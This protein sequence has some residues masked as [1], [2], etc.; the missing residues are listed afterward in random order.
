MPIAGMPPY[1]SSHGE[2][3]FGGAVAATDAEGAPVH[4]SF[5]QQSSFS[6]MALATQGNVVPVSKDLDLATLA[7]LGCGIQT[8]AGGVLNS[9]QARAG[10]SIGVF[11][12]GAVGLSAVMAAQ[13][14]GCSRIVAVDVN[15]S[16]LD[17]ARQL[18][19]THTVHVTEAG[20]TRDLVLEATTGK[21]GLDHAFDTSG[22]AGVIRT[23]VECLANRGV[24]GFV[25]PGQQLA[26][27]SMSLLGG[28][29]LR[30]V[31]QGDSVPQTFIP[32]MVD[33]Y[34]GGRFP[35]DKLITFYDNGLE[36]LNCAIAETTAKDSAVIKPVLKISPQ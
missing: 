16:R 28:K 15:Q 13:V 3:N 14:A 6:T 17:I 34:L 2:L 1:C 27:D 25:A 19:A 18:G 30:G 24:C 9:L 36:D 5:F 31:I 26:V 32:T 22:N 11:G 10:S 21:L 12:C 8:G 33:L 35:F 4:T 29:A 20:S 23:A 7:P